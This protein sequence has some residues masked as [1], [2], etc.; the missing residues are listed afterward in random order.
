MGEIDKAKELFN[1]LS[2]EQFLAGAAKHKKYVPSKAAEHADFCN[3]FPLYIHVD[4][5]L[6]YSFLSH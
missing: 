2:D 6:Q 5:C 3:V 1:A 4:M